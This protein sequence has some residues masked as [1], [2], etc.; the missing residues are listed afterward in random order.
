ME[1]HVDLPLAGLEGLGDL[2]DA[3]GLTVFVQ[4]VEALHH[5]SV[6]VF[7]GHRVERLRT[8]LE[9]RKSWKAF[10]ITGVRQE[11]DPVLLA[12]DLPP[13]FFHC[14]ELQRILDAHGVVGGF[15][16]PAAFALISDGALGGMGG[17][18]PQ[19]DRHQQGD[20]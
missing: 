14:L 9:G 12:R 13:R 11:G 6:R 20:H 3:F 16:P 2:Q 18:R 19:K 17:H 5:R 1:R 8:D 7:E 4:Q 10:R 15:Q